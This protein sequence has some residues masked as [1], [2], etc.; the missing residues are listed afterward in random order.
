[1]E[2]FKYLIDDIPTYLMES[3][4][5][6]RWK[7]FNISLNQQLIQTDNVKP[8]QQFKGLDNLIVGFALQ[9]SMLINIIS[10]WFLLFMHY[11]T[12]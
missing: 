9:K 5:H 4:I 7:Y 12:E 3:S 8:I 6:F 10:C 11:S 2:F 1:M